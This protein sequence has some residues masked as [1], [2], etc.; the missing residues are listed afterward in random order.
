M[1]V[2]AEEKADI[3]RLAGSQRAYFL[4]GNTQSL[5][6]RKESLRKLRD[7][8]KA[9]EDEIAEAVCRDFGKSYFEVMQNE[10][11]LVYVEIRH[12]L[13]MLKRWAA[14]GRPRT[15]LPNLP[16]K[17][18]VY[19]VPYGNV[20]VI[21]PW[22][23]PLQLALIPAVSA[24]AAGNTVILKP[25]ELTVHSSGIMAKLINASFPGELFH[26]VEG[27]VPVTTALLKMKFD[28]IFFTGSTRVGKIVMKAAAE[29]LTPVTLELGGKNPVIVMPD[30][31]L[32]MTARRLVWGKFHNNGQACVVPDHIYVHEEIMD[33]LIAA[34]KQQIERLYPGDRSKCEVGP[35]I[36]DERHYDRLMK[37]IQP[38]KL[39]LGGTGNREERFIEPTVMRGVQSGDPVMQEEIFGPVMPFLVYKDLEELLAQLKQQPSPLALYIFTRNT[40]RAAA[41]QRAF[42]SGGGMVNDTVVHFVNHNAPFGGIGESGMGAYHGRTG[43]ECFTHRKSVLFK[44]TWFELPVKY[45]PYT[46]FKLRVIRAFLR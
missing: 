37:L 43:F 16:G 24:L 23:Y 12:T 9:H 18:R 26:V 33:R 20:L 45:P 32:E 40:R 36:I 7:L 2:K 8:L 44:P 25:S 1:S 46:K 38:E 5:N 28:K 41:I 34:V 4:A 17:S 15:S 21:A 30:C 22:N 42:R 10:L 11:G 13:R 27:G 19:A 14:P 6:R 39:V 35:S 31:D 29:H 3:S